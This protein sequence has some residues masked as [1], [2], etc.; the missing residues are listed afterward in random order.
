V[1]KAKGAVYLQKE[2][3]LA[4]CWVMPIQEDLEQSPSSS[5]SPSRRRTVAGG[6]ARSRRPDLRRDEPKSARRSSSAPTASSPMS[7]R[8]SRISSGSSDCSAAIFTTGCLARRR[9]SPN[10]YGRRAPMVARATIRIS[11]ARRTSTTSSTC[12]SHI[13]RSSSSRR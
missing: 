12:D 4:G 13:Y 6:R 5:P 8:T 9:S 11:A 10:R 3:R 1:L 2:G 7:A